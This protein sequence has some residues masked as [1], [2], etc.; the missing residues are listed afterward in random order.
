M[1]SAP[2]I[3]MMDRLNE[4]WSLHTMH[5]CT[6]CAWL[7]LA[8][9]CG[10]VLVWNTCTTCIFLRCLHRSKYKQP[11]R[12][13]DYWWSL[14]EREL[15]KYTVYVGWTIDG[16]S[17]KGSLKNTPYFCT[18]Y[19]YLRSAYVCAWIILFNIQRWNRL[20]SRAVLHRWST[21][22]GARW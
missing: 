15:K 8:K 17:K 2:Q 18:L 5:I 3:Q 19:A 13:M 7:N 1:A 21:M 14:K 12:W 20:W 16:P 10:S 22:D 9:V 6:F 4:G 11:I